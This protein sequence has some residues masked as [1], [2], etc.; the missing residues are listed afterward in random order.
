MHAGEVN[1]QSPED[2]F[3]VVK[4]SPGAAEHVIIPGAEIVGGR[5]PWLGAD[6][7]AGEEELATGSVA[8]L[9]TGSPAARQRLMS[10]QR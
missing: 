6:S 10:A 5:G 7:L 9:T 8:K 2:G 1:A 3:A 4:V